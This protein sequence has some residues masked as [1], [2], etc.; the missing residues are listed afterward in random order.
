MKGIFKNAREKEK[1]PSSCLLSYL[2]H[3][4]PCTVVLG[5][6]ISTV[7]SIAS[8][9][10]WSY[11]SLNGGIA[12][13]C[14]TSLHGTEFE[15]LPGLGAQGREEACQVHPDPDTLEAVIAPSVP[16]PET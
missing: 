3:A 12:G 1:V 16:V 7:P 2:V 14:S 4:G 11:L 10:P 6:V 15:H 13:S 8:P 9:R 5:F